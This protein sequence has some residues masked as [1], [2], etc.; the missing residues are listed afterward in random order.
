MLDE[1]VVSELKQRFG[2]PEQRSLYLQEYVSGLESE[3]R[4]TEEAL[5]KV[6]EQLAGLAEEEAHVRK[7]FRQQALSLDEFRQMSDD[8]KA[9]AAELRGREQIL[10]SR[11]SDLRATIGGQA[12]LLDSA[13]KV[14]HWDQLDPIE[15]KNVLRFFVD[16]V[17][18]YK[19]PKSDE[20][21]CEITWKSA[22]A[23]SEAEARDGA[24]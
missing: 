5:R 23:S 14:D 18:A 16:R 3:V 20:I 12:A 8:L 2:L 1:L 13:R 21:C 24:P 17:R 7:H 9:E 4:S 19:R 10:S 6:Q 15:Q 11:L 22:S